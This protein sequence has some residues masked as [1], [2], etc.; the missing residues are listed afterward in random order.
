M[1]GLRIEGSMMLLMRPWIGTCEETG[2]RLSDHLEHEL[3]PRE[4]RRVRRH[5]AWCRPCR[6]VFESLSRV[7]EDVRALGRSDE[8]AETPSVASAVVE[9]IRHERR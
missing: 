1:A 9:R 7:V 2:A 6:A 4:E 5:L 8:A 3:G